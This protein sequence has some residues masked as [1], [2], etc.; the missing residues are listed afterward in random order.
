MIKFIVAGLFCGIAFGLMYMVTMTYQVAID[1]NEFE[2]GA[3]YGTLF[4]EITSEV[5]RIGDGQSTLNSKEY[6]ALLEGI[7]FTYDTPCGDTLLQYKSA[8]S[9]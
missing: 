9:K 5:N 6:G 4:Q 2:S 1:A 7:S 3:C 8:M